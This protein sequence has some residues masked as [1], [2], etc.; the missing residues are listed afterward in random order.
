MFVLIGRPFGARV[1]ID[2]NALEAQFRRPFQFTACP[3]DVC[4]MNHGGAVKALSRMTA[5]FCQPIVK[6]GAAILHQRIVARAHG[7]EHPRRGEDFAGCDALFQSGTEIG[8]DRQAIG[9]DL[10][11]AD[12]ALDGVDHFPHSAVIPSSWPQAGSLSRSS[13]AMGTPVCVY[14]YAL[15]SSMVPGSVA[16]G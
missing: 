11:A 6:Y 13:R 1:T 14:S 8:E 5:I 16:S 3:I 15:R 12:Q 7:V 2:D 10:A 9:M 4:H